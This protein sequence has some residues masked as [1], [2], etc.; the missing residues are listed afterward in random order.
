MDEDSLRRQNSLHRDEDYDHKQGVMQ[1]IDPNH[2]GSFRRER[3]VN[4]H[5]NPDFAATM[6]DLDELFDREETQDLSPPSTTRSSPQ[7]SPPKHQSPLRSDNWNT[8]PVRS[9]NSSFA[10]E[11]AEQDLQVRV[12]RS[13]YYY[14][15]IRIYRNKSSLF[16]FHPFSYFQI[17]ICLMLII[18]L[19][20]LERD[21]LYQ[22]QAHQ[23]VKI[24]TWIHPHQIN[25]YYFLFLVL[26]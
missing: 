22:K 24:N 18:C 1:D 8:S 2:S 3:I 15:N 17:Y 20:R 10:N 21:L 23:Q 12:Q 13:L 16:L 9:I 7:R 5:S 6:D 26:I 4:Q 11:Q 25:L 19:L 14:F